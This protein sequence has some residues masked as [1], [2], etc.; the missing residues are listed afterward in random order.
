[1]KVFVVDISGR[2]LKYDVALCDAMYRSNKEKVDVRLMC[3]LYSSNKK[4]FA[5]W[6]LNLIPRK[7]RNS[8]NCWKRVIKVIEI[9]FNYILVLYRVARQKPSIVHFQWFPLLEII[10]IEPYFVKTMKFFSKRTKMVL[11]IHNVY[12]HN[13]SEKKKKEYRTRFSKL[14]K[15]IDGYIVHTVDT[16]KQVENNFALNKNTVYV[17]HHGIFVPENFIP[18]KN[19]VKDNKVCFIMYGSLSSYKGVDLFVDAFKLLP[20]VY[21]DKARGVIAGV[22]N[23]KSLYETLRKES[24]S[25]NIVWYPYFLPEQELYERI[26]ESNVIVLP[27]R[28]ISQSGV[29]L[30]ALSF[31]RFIITSD[32]PA[33]KETL[34]GFSDDMFFNNGNA[35]SLSKLMAK[36]IDSKIDSNS[37][38]HSIER[39]NQQYSWEKAGEKTIDVYNSLLFNFS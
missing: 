17:V 5:N 18:N 10:S 8:E 30:L 14:S 34:K 7:Y 15:V 29:L 13:S 19:I 22:F 35:E 20:Q 27:Y 38:L 39:L 23:D 12:P 32:L 25:L 16:K 6:M 33:F 3:P 9:L 24:E 4:C 37:E 31:H 26:D 36:Y 28:Q 1:M 2:V 21:K 11:T